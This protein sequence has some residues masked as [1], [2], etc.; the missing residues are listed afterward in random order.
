LVKRREWTDPSR[1]FESSIRLLVVVFGDDGEKKEH[2]EKRVE[3]LF[4]FVS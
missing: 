3:G 4:M 1:T 2:R